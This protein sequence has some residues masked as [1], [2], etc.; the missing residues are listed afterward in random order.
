MASAE[1]PSNQ[2]DTRDVPGKLTNVWF[3]VVKCNEGGK[4]FAKVPPFLINICLITA[5]GSLKSVTKLRIGAQLTELCSE[6]EC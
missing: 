1:D 4:S 2:M 3:L 5:C 6:D